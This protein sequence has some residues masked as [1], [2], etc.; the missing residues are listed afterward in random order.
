MRSLLVALAAAA[1]LCLAL[2]VAA[3][4]AAYRSCPQGSSP[5]SFYGLKRY[6][7]TCRQARA[8]L[9]AVDR[10]FTASGSAQTLPRS[11]EGYRCTYRRSDG[12]DFSG[13][14]FSKSRNE[15]IRFRGAFVDA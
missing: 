12:I 1:L 9:R 2:P 4:G 14:C 15:G 6:N 11:V 13:R 8:L 10:R 5:S 3:Q 7:M